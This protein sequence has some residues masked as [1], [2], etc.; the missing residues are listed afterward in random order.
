MKR[1]N[2]ERFM[3]VQIKKIQMDKWCEGV[4]VKRDPGRD[5]ILDWIQRNGYNFRIGWEASACK[6]CH[7]WH[8]CGH[9]LAIN[10]EFYQETIVQQYK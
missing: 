8:E 3:K 9:K 7:H 4:K 10:C 6:T 1:A 2:M 5:Y